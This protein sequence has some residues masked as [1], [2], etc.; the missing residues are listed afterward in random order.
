MVFLYTMH[1]LLCGQLLAILSVAV[2]QQR[3][4]LCLLHSSSLSF[5]LKVF[6]LE[7]PESWTSYLYRKWN[8]FSDCW[9][10]WTAEIYSHNHFVYKMVCFWTASWSHFILEDFSFKSEVSLLE[11]FRSRLT[12][13]ALPICF[14]KKTII[15]SI[16]TISSS[17]FSSGF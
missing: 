14:R 16:I 4:A 9:N 12:F 6:T 3:Q 5:W 7:Y 13:S 2:K 11:K 17:F 1:H 15:S 10:W 8:I